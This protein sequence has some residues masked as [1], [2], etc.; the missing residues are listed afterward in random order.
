LE[1]DLYGKCPT[2][3]IIR[4]LGRVVEHRLRESGTN[5]RTLVEKALKAGTFPRL[6]ADAQRLFERGAH[7]RRIEHEMSIEDGRLGQCSGIPLSTGT[8]GSVI[9]P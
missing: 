3:P 2:E 4:V 6:E 7:D 5:S 9:L 1:V 8:M